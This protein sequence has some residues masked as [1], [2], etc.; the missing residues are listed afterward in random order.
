[1][2]G[3]GKVPSYPTTGSG[4][5][6]AG[7]KMQEPFSAPAAL[8]KSPDGKAGKEPVVGPAPQETPKHK[9]GQQSPV[10][11]HGKDHAA[12]AR[13]TRGNPSKQAPA[14]PS[15]EKTAKGPAKAPAKGVFGKMAGFF[16]RLFGRN[17]KTAADAKGKAEAAPG[18]GGSGDTAGSKKPSLPPGTPQ[19]QRLTQRPDEGYMTFI[20]RIPEDHMNVA[21]FYRSPGYQGKDGKAPAKDAGKAETP[22]R[23]PMPPPPRATPP[24]PKPGIADPRIQMAVDKNG[25]LRKV[26]EGTMESYMAGLP[27]SEWNKKREFP[28]F[29]EP[30]NAGRPAPAGRPAAAPAGGQVRPERQYRKIR[31]PQ[32][33]KR[34]DESFLRELGRLKPPKHTHDMSAAYQ[35]FEALKLKARGL[36]ADGPEPR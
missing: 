7:K 15:S 1:M 23:R 22:V 24:A 17:G 32:A 20:N 16:Q 33:P 21:H 2:G 13:K 31:T 11:L 36:P 35:R 3:F 12:E 18:K 5:F 10:S 14:A 29:V 30:R 27:K 19:L 8:A 6:R 28:I 4:G 9:P 25:R 34:S 26:F